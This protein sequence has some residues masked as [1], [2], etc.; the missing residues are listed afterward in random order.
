[1]PLENPLDCPFLRI[2]HPHHRLSNPPDRFTITLRHSTQD[3]TTSI[4]LRDCD[5]NTFGH[6]HIKFY[7][8]T[9]PPSSTAIPGKFLYPLIHYIASDKFSYHYWYF[10]AFVSADIEPTKFSD[11]ISNPKWHLA[12]QQKIDDLEHSG[13]WD[14]TTLPLG[15]RALGS[16]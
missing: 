10:L 9:A 5:C 2:I 4:K 7:S 16:K 11:T 1:M 8:F 12:I 14:L 6:S 13:T 3:R 15:K